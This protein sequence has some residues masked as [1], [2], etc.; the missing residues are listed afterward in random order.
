MYHNMYIRT[1]APT[2]TSFPIHMAPYV[3]TYVPTYILLCGLI[4]QCVYG[5]LSAVTGMRLYLTHNGGSM[6]LLVETVYNLCTNV[7]ILHFFEYLCFFNFL[8]SDVIPIL[9]Q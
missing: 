9:T 5:M 1:Y 7:F 2:H 4:K 6:V 3:R 8:I